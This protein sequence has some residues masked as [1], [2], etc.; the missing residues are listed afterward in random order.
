MIVER[1]GW[2]LAVVA[3]AVVHGRLERVRFIVA[4]DHA[5]LATLETLWMELGPLLEHHHHRAG[6][7]ARTL[8]APLA[9]DLIVVRATVETIIALVVAQRGR[10][11]VVVVAR[12]QWLMA[13]CTPGAG[14]GEEWAKLDHQH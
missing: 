7:V 13:D 3:V 5:T 6:H 12:G 14:H 4:Y 2:C 11:V 1:N 9:V 10:R 8:G